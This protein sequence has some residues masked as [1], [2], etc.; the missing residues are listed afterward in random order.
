MRQQSS[1]LGILFGGFIGYYIFSQNP[2]G[3]IIGAVVG[4]FIFERYIR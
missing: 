4:Y 2:L 3:A 1:I